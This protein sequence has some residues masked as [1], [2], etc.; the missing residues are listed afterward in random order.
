[1]RFPLKVKATILIVVISIL[2]SGVCIVALSNSSQQL[3]IDQYIARASDL[4]NVAAA[5]VDVKSLEAL[6]SDVDKT[7]SALPENER[8]SN[9]EWGEP[10]WE[11]YLENFDKIEQSENFQ[12]L[13]TWLR[14]MQDASSAEYLYILYPD[15]EKESFVYLVDASY[16]DNCRPGSFDWYT[17]KDVESMK[18]PEEGLQPDI[19]NTNYGWLV[20]VG[21][22]IY[23]DAGEIIAFV[24]SD[25]SMD[26]VMAD[27]Q[28]FLI[29][30]GLLVVGLTIACVIVGVVL[31]SRFVVNPVKVLTAA[32]VDYVKRDS[33]ITHDRFASLDIRTG[34]EIETLADSM[35]QME[36]DMNDH[37]TKLLA[38][39][40]ELNTTREFA[41]EMSEAATHDALTKTFSK[42]AYDEK[43][44]ELDEE[45]AAG[46]ASFGIAMIDLNFLKELNDQHGHDKGDLALQGVVRE[47]G[48]CFAD[49]PL[50]RVGGDEFVLVMCPWDDAVEQE[51]IARFKER[52]ATLSDDSSLEPW[53]R[54]SAAVG[55]AQFDASID[56]SAADVLRRADEAM[57]VNKKAMKAGR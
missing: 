40:E 33:S 50:Y 21:S 3:V 45:I 27:Q 36:R 31:V 17:E 46:D 54:L 19:T 37:V 11:A 2:L 43:A 12:S 10:E 15:E 26:K 7:Y 28:Q 29:L 8:V 53:E 30:V 32:S 51:R 6:R 48:S 1:M 47:I 13:Q 18:T 34:D 42:R 39:T 14:T 41:D 56:S 24:C 9:E 22:P 35:A 44:A 20:A 49:T 25:Y 4:T 16:E 55:Y 57:Y 38:Q 52:I 23:N 5:S